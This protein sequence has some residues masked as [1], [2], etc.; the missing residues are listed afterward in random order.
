VSSQH[1]HPP[2]VPCYG[3]VYPVVLGGAGTGRAQGRHGGGHE[4]SPPLLSPPSHCPHKHEYLPSG[5]Q[6]GACLAI[7]STCLTFAQTRERMAPLEC[8]G[9]PATRRDPPTL[10]W[11]QRH[12]GAV[13]NGELATSRL[14]CGSQCHHH[15]PRQV[16][17]VLYCVM[18]DCVNRAHDLQQGGVD[19]LAPY[20][21]SAQAHLCAN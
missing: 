15:S 20:L 21:R 4:M 7:S 11:P 3:R 12:C 17:G 5:M 6:G 9:H 10:S 1:L 8:C 16:G 18:H 19:D 2:H 13:S 14:M